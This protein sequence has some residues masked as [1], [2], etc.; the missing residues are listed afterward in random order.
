MVCIIMQ[1]VF[2]FLYYQV[3]LK[4][5]YVFI[6]I[7]FMQQLIIRRLSKDPFTPHPD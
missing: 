2:Y 3:L 6:L 1:L 7:A 5:F 4:S